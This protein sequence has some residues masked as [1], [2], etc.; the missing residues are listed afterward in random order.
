MILP[1]TELAAILVLILGMLGWGSW[2]NTFKLGGKWRYELY[3]FDWIIGAMAA[4]LILALTAGSMGYDGFSLRDDLMIA[5][6]RQWLWAFLAGVIFNI[7][8]MMLLACLSLAG[9]AV[10]FPMAAGVALILSAMA[11][12]ALTQFGPPVFVLL[13]CALLAGAVVASALVY[14]HV[15]VLR[16]EQIARAGKAKSTRRPGSAKAIVL[17]MVSG[18]FLGAFPSLLDLARQ[19]EIGL[20]P[21]AT[22]VLF[23]LGALASSTMLNLFLMNLP[24]EGEP[25][26]VLEYLRATWTNHLWGL[27]GGAIWSVGLI[28]LLVVATLPEPTRPG[29]VTVYG[30]SQGWV[31]VASLWG[32]LVWK[33]LKGGDGR[34]KVLEGL[35]LL[36]LVGG[37]LVL[38]V[39]P[40]FV[41]R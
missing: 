17:A 24:V 19:G 4:A 9:M 34:V 28:A 14:Q 2:A 15:L 36:L 3:Y 11:S 13:G 22:A 30:L 21:Y 38:A 18:L 20:G 31:I 1:H 7:G 12:F 27:A 35:K 16:H 26:E 25:L 8:N 6:K 32:S 29:P 41:K 40:L 33:E 5:G 10:A 37:I 23:V 39:A